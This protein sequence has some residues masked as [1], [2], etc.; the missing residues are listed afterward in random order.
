MITR[1]F[2]GA[3]LPQITFH[4]S[5]LPMYC[6]PKPWVDNNGGGYLVIHTDMLRLPPQA[7]QQ[8]ERVNQH[9]DKTQL[10]PSFDSL[11]QL[12]AVPWC[13]NE[14]IL[15]LLIDIFQSGGNSRLGVAQHPSTC[16]APPPLGENPTKQER[17]QAFRLRLAVR[18]RKA[19]MYSLWCDALYRLSLA[20]HVSLFFETFCP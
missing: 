11:N 9:S 20:N 15:D 7:T 3:A 17:F 2:Q 10:Y 4:A 8:I 13:V 19:E 18:R 16:A 12:G 5:L 14:P 1:L 6:P